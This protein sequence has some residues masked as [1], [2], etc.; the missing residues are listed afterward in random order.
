MT[1]PTPPTE[2]T[3]ADLPVVFTVDEGQMI[4][5]GSDQVN[6]WL[7]GARPGQGKSA[8]VHQVLAALQTVY[9]AMEQRAQAIKQM[10]GER[11]PSPIRPVRDAAPTPPRTVAAPRNPARSNGNEVTPS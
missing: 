8:A 2:P 1:T 3:A 11:T 7:I 9:R 10:A 4:L 6:D 5:S